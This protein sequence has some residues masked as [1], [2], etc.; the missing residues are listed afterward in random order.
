VGD[1]AMVAGQEEEEEGR[2]AEAEAGLAGA[3]AVPVLRT[4]APP[5]SVG[6]AWV[7]SLSTGYTCRC[8]C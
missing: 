8:L 4:T 6:L 2:V 1:L 5:R 3:V 7:R